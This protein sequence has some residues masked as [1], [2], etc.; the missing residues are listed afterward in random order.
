[1]AKLIFNFLVLLGKRRKVLNGPKAI[2]GDSKMP[3]LLPLLL[4]YLGHS[5]EKKWDKL[6]S[7][8]V[9]P[10][11]RGGHEQKFIDS[12]WGISDRQQYGSTKVQV[13]EPMS[14]LGSLIKWCYGSWLICSSLP[15]G[16]RASSLLPAPMFWIPK[17]KTHIHS[18]IFKYALNSSMVGPLSNLHVANASPP[19]LLSYYL[20]KS[21]FCLCCPRRGWGNWGPPGATLFLLLLV[22]Y[23]S[24]L[25]FSGPV[26][27]LSGHGGSISFFFPHFPC[28]QILKFYLCLPTQPLATGN[29]I[30]Q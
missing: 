2:Q 21:I 13:S 16:N 17:W 3:L 28:L 14:F 22:G 30:Y 12:R 10:M 15:R 9:V 4:S 29:F 1:M 11:F 18:L 7:T 8:W 6:G 24:D 26:F 25:Y 23:L 20:L 19:R 5:L 27:L